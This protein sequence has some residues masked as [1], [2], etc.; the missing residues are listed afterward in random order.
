[1]P[2]TVFRFFDTPKIAATSPGANKGQTGN[3]AAPVPGL[4]YK[5]TVIETAK[6]GRVKVETP[7]GEAVARSSYNAPLRPG[8]ECIIMNRNGTWFLLGA[9]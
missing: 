7:F 9:F 4:A 6:R 8:Q 2:A 5:S 3:L 1:M